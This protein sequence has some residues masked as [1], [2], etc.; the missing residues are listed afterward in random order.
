MKNISNKTD[1]TSTLAANGFNSLMQENE[2]AVLASGQTLDPSAE[3][4]ADPDVEQLARSMTMAAQ[5]ADFYEDGGTANAYVL[6]RVGDWVQPE[7][8]FDGMQVRFIPDNANTGASTI[9]ISTIGTRN[10]KDAAG[11]ALASGALQTG[12]VYSAYYNL[13][14]DEFR[15]SSSS[16]VA[17]DSITNA[18]LANMAAN[19]VKVNATS[20]SAN[21]T[22]LALAASQL[23][24]RGSTGN[25]AAITM[26]TNVSMTGTTLN[27]TAGKTLQVLQ[28]VKTDTFSTTASAWVD[29][30]GL[31]VSITPSAT[32]SRVKIICSVNVGCLSAATP[33]H[34]RLTR[35]GTPICVGDAASARSQA[36][37]ALSNDSGIA[38][39]GQQSMIMSFVDSPSTTSST[40]YAVQMWSVNGRVNRENGDTD[41]ALT[42]R[43]ASTIIVEEIGA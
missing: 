28:T 19:T 16:G 5:S 26:G 25:L 6:S 20:G 2:N 3:T 39:D 10:L 9:N 42:A 15:V 32:S 23:L 11:T 27:V 33:L 24:G 38:S 41:T 43:A 29:V 21:P 18:K 4:A 14:S 8:Y 37:S 36:T 35:G 13:A 17:D 7:A 40:T 1:L 22:D 30:T 12:I 31:S 34:L